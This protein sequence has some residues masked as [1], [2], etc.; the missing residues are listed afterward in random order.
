MNNLVDGLHASGQCTKRL[1]IFES[2]SS[3]ST[4][5]CR[6]CYHRRLSQSTVC[7]PCGYPSVGYEPSNWSCHGYYYHCLLLHLPWLRLIVVLLCGVLLLAPISEPLSSWLLI[8]KKKWQG[9]Y[10]VFPVSLVRTGSRHS[11]KTLVTLWSQKRLKHLGLLLAIFKYILAA[12]ENFWI[13]GSIAKKILHKNQYQ[14]YFRWRRLF[15]GRQT[16]LGVV[17]ICPVSL[18]NFSKSK[19]NR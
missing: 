8:S 15:D 9:T 2:T 3:P 11:Q 10:C 14:C 18:S 12:V 5:R 7:I 13:H 6:L 16:D 1:S 4:C 17:F 19:R